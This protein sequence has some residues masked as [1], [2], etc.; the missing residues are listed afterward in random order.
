M[1]WRAVSFLRYRAE[2]AAAGIGALLESA[3]ITLAIPKEARGKA[4]K[5]TICM[6]FTPPH[7]SLFTSFIICPTSASS[8]VSVWICFSIA[9]MFECTVA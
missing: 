8:T 7:Q 6:Y 3:K 2:V 5:Y 4:H 9:L 1:H